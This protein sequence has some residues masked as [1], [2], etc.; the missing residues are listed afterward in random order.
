MTT[1]PLPL[2]NGGS[3]LTNVPHD[4]PR[5]VVVADNA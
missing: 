2:A 3:F 5:W 4:A 1:A